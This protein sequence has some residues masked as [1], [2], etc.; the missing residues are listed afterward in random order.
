MNAIT[1]LDL[2]RLEDL[3]S[4]YEVGELIRHWPAANG[5]ENSNYFLSTVRAGS[6]RQY[7]LTLLERPANAGGA[8]VPLLDTCVAAGLPVPAV[9]RDRRGLAFTDLDGKPAMLCPRLPG[10]HVYNP[11]LRQVEALG[12]FIGHFHLATADADLRLP[13]YPRDL[14]WLA[15]IADACR[16][17]AGY[18]AEALMD[19]TRHQLENALTRTDVRSLPRG[20]VHAD[21][22]RD[23]VL[24]N[25]WGLSGVLD[26]HHASQGYLIYDLAVAA[27]DWCTEANGALDPERTLALLRAYHGVRPLRREELWHFPVFTLYGALA[28]WESRLV[29]ALEKRRGRSVR[30]NNPDEF[31]RMVRHHS[32]HFFY[33]DER[34]LSAGP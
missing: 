26:F 11:T 1:E 3:I 4:G 24:F 22:F 5:I 30:A 19:D 6:E 8:F 21:L 33:L 28:F 29:V 18:A 13:D 12:R 16:G 10:R 20:P 15:R 32:A 7:V 27:N 31:E 9:L 17:Y 34:R 23:N 25:E 2:L 14:N